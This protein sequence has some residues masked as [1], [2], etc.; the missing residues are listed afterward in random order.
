ML[1]E[2]QPIFFRCRRKYRREAGFFFVESTLKKKV[3]RVKQEQS[4]KT[5]YSGWFGRYSYPREKYFAN[6]DGPLT[7]PQQRYCRCVLH[8]AAQQSPSCLSEQ[9]WFATREGKQCYNPYAVCAASVHTSS[10][11]S[12][13]YAFDNIPTQELYAYA[14][15]RQK[16]WSQYFGSRPEDLP[17]DR[18]QLLRLIKTF[19]AETKAGKRKSVFVI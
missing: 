1:D 12:P 7:D 4:M 15:L 16:T 14:L 5:N 19:V 17:T 2:Q 11:C 8:V 13:S 10:H 3:C 6:H 9:A 18:T